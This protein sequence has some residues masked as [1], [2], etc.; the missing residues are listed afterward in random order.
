MISMLFNSKNLTLSLL[1]VVSGSCSAAEIDKPTSNE[2]IAKCSFFYVIGRLKNCFKPKVTA[3]ITAEDNRELRALD[4]LFKKFWRPTEKDF[5]QEAQKELLDL[6]DQDATN[7][8]ELRN[9]MKKDHE[10]DQSALRKHRPQ[11]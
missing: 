3:E 6:L 10:K 7:P 9:L 8:A 4:T 2:P 1:F 11:S 5:N